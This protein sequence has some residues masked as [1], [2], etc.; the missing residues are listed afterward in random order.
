MNVDAVEEQADGTLKVWFRL[1]D[2]EAISESAT[3][4]H[5][6]AANELI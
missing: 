1:V 4:T 5:V 6:L 2:W 3:V